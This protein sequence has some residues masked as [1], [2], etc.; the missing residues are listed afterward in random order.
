VDIDCRLW[1]VSRL[2]SWPA[3]KRTLLFGFSSDWAAIRKV[4]PTKIRAQD[5]TT[6][7]M[8]ARP[9]AA[10]LAHSAVWLRDNCPCGLCR[11]PGN[12]QKLFG[13]TDLDPDLIVTSVHG[14]AVTFSDGHVSRFD[15]SFLAATGPVDDRNEDGKVIGLP[16]APH[17]VEWSRFQAGAEPRADGLEALL[18]NGFVLLTGVPVA[19][20][21]VLEVV[22][23]FGYVRETNYGRLFDVQV[24]A[25]PTNLAFTTNAIAPHTD[26][27]YRDPVPTVQLLHCRSNAV[28]GGDS[29]LVDGFHAAALLRAEDLKAFEV[30]A[31]TPVTFRYADASTELV[32][33][34]PLIG[35]DG[36]GR[37]REVRLNERSMQPLRRPPD[38]IAAFYAAYRSFV[39]ITHRP[40]LMLTLRLMPGDCLVFDN[41]RMLHARTGFV[42]T[43]TGLA[44]GS[45]HLQG[46]Y[47]DLD[48]VA[49]RLKVLRGEIATER[50]RELFA[51]PG[52]ADYLGED[53]SQ[54]QHMLQTAALAAREQATPELIIAAL[55]HDVGHFT[56]SITGHDL[57]AGTDNRHSHVGADWLA[58][59][60]APA[61]TEPIRH[62]VAAKRYL[63]AIDQDYYGQLS[64]ASKYTLGVQGGPMSAEERS[65]FEDEPYASDAIRLRRW[66]DSAKD[67][68]AHVEPFDSY[69]LDL[70]R[71]ARC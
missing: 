71:L 44:H 26:N 40:E 50:I 9:S 67:A 30:L 6:L 23:S 46:C 25:S 41:T 28:A 35:L 12:G 27:P 21:T 65:M 60:F 68:G 19:L 64:D 20:G 34:A 43:D 49:S 58:Q 29:G 61:V 22:E 24:E 11:H 66:D 55:L 10:V 14:T 31:S 32:A 7:T 8:S 56:G 69:A 13:I 45:R 36:D 18:R 51:G 39:A 53:V 15:P 63:C 33:T 3:V 4:L 52:R 59:W 57:M 5:V 38:D 37:I 70:A 17:R 54:A 2:Y 42:E 48:A 47:A 62:H 16:T 1:I